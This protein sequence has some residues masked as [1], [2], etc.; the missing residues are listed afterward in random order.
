MTKI[1]SEGQTCDSCN[2]LVDILIPIRILCE[3]KSGPMEMQL[4]HYCPECFDDITE[5]WEH[6]GSEEEKVK[7]R[8]EKDLFWS[9]DKELDVWH[10]GIPKR[11]RITGEAIR[12]LFAH[13]TKG[14]FEKEKWIIAWYESDD[15]EGR[16]GY[17]VVS[18]REYAEEVYD[19]IKDGENCEEVVLGAVAKRDL[20]VEKDDGESVR[21]GKRKDK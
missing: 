14:N 1:N 18:S 9:Y 2:R 12:E 4:R 17:Q 6:K 10:F 13:I 20:L 19:K 16:T 3:T 15:E 7:Q 8:K 5:G 11:L 21:K